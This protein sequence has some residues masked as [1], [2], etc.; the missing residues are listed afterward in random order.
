[1]ST[2][3]RDRRHIF[4][5]LL[6]GASGMLGN[7]LIK[8]LGST[9]EVVGKSSKNFDITDREA[10]REEILTTNPH[11][12]IN[13]AGFTHVDGCEAEVEKAFMVNGDG[14]KNVAL[15]CKE[16]KIKLLHISTD[17]VFDGKKEEPYLED[18]RPS[19]LNVYGKSKLQGEQYIT[20]IMEEFLIVRTE[21]LYGKSGHNFVDTILRLARVEEELKV[22]NDQIGSPTYTKDLAYAIDTLLE[23][24]LT[25]VYHVTNSGMCSWY[26][27]ATTILKLA[28]IQ[29]VKVEPVNSD[30][31][32]RPA[33]RPAFSA[34]NCS[35]F[36]KE[37]GYTMRTWDAALAEYFREYYK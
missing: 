20:E 11:I 12:V 24:D 27:F 7:D 2:P 9:R 25:G 35:K 23:H 4:K 29:N 3:A 5:I 15:A 21:W 26:E 8:V 13:S 34:L 17:Y 18:D 32:T 28:S 37:T 6:L 31:Y 19:P 33:K 16:G 22:V 30:T 10:T 1:M 14:A 36:E